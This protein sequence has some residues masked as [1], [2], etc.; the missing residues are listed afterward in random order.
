MEAAACLSW[1]RTDQAVAA[2]AGPCAAP[3]PN[4]LVYADT[5]P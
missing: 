4:I 3:R 2:G 5:L 1:L